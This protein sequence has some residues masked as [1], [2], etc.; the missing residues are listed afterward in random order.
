MPDA[1]FAVDAAGLLRVWEEQRA[2]HPLVR[3]LHLLA[4][5]RPERG[6]DAWSHAPIGDRDAAL[7]A[8]HEHLFGSALHATIACPHCGER[9]ES[10]FHALDMRG[11]GIAPEAPAAELRLCE[12]GY[13]IDY[14]LP[15]SDDLLSLAASPGEPEAPALKLLRRCVSR[16][17]RGA[18]G[19]DVAA[20]PEAVVAELGDRMARQDPGADVR[21]VLD[22]PAC[23]TAW[24]ARFDIVSYLWGEIE[25]WAQRMLAD[26]HALARAYGW[27]ERA[28]LRLGP[29]RRQAYLDM[30]AA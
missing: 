8:V 30:V 10:S 20:L 4:A 9:L 18:D 1:L 14:R 13:A 22:C 6:Y 15:T 16:A 25:D 3:A 26:V 28:I 27:S 21:I 23:G 5:A 2:A 29:L 11:S 12:A 24:Q 19:I 7:L 17:Q